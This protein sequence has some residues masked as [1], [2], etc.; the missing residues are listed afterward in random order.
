[1]PLIPPTVGR[2]MW[3]YQK[4]QRFQEQPM[5]AT[6]AHVWSDT[7]V[8]AGITDREGKPY[9]NPPTSIRIVHDG[10]EVPVD[11]KGLVKENFLMWMP[12]QVGQ[13]KKH[14]EPG[15]AT[16]PGPAEHAPAGGSHE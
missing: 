8:N 6:V 7:C 4:G 3:F 2:V 1:M 12:Y 9:A 5:A 10:E 13:A 16:E 14:A 11:N 15:K